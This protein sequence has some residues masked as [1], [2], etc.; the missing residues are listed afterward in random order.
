MLLIAKKK[1]YFTNICNSILD[2]V[3]NM[4]HLYIKL[5][6]YK[7]EKHICLF[8][9]IQ[10]IKIFHFIFEIHLKIA[11]FLINLVLILIIFV[12]KLLA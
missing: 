2:L 6:Q 11:Q 7:L 5:Q 1:K 8:I 4:Y 12:Q 3:I 10:T 9:L